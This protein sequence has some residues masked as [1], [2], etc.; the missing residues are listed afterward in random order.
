MKQPSTASQICITFIANLLFGIFYFEASLPL[1]AQYAAIWTT[2]ISVAIFIRVIFPQMINNGN[3][4]LAWAVLLV[5]GQ[6]AFAVVF[7][8]ISTED[9][10]IFAGIYIV[11]MFGL[12]ILVSVIKKRVES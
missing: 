12:G 6:A 7:F 10:F 3:R 5:S 1:S 4:A 8:G 11:S 9:A 2:I